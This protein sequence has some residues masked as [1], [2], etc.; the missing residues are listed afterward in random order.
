IE[1]RAGIASV[2]DNLAVAGLHIFDKSVAVNERLVIARI[3][4]DGWVSRIDQIELPV[5]GAKP[6]V[7]HYSAGRAVLQGI[8]VGAGSQSIVTVVLKR[9]ADGVGVAVMLL[10]T[11]DIPVA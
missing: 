3:R 1:G 7:A 6:V 5:G 10:G 9:D 2:V 4:N 11:S 8:A